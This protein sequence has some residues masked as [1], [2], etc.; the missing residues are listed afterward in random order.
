MRKLTKKEYIEDL[1][2]CSRFVRCFHN[3]DFEEVFSGLSKMNFC[4]IQDWTV[5]RYHKVIT[6]SNHIEMVKDDG[7]VSRYFNGKNR[8]YTYKGVLYHEQRQDDH[9]CVFVNC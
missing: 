9:V 6:K 7:T 3:H 8:Y 2:C 5:Y 1:E 4:D